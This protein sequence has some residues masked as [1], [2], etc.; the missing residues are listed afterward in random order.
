MM[1]RVIALGIIAYFM[2][3]IARNEIFSYL[4][5]SKI[6]YYETYSTTTYRFDIGNANR[7]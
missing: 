3:N 7:C 6:S 5:K 4:Y 2:A 1:P